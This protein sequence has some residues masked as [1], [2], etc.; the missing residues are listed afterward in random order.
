MKMQDTTHFQLRMKPC[1]F[2]GIF[3]FDNKKQIILQNPDMPLKQQ[4]Y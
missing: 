2:L 1:V 4:T 3:P